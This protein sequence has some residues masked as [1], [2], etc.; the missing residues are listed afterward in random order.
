MNFGT[1]TVLSST[2]LGMR[3]TPIPTLIRAINLL[4]GKHGEHAASLIL[5]NI[6]TRW[7]P[8]DGT[9]SVRRRGLHW[10]L[11]LGD[12]LQRRLYFVG[13]YESITL[14]ALLARVRPHDTVLDVGAN[15]GAIALPI[16][17]RLRPPGQVIAVE[18]AKDTVERLRRHVFL[19]HLGDRIKVIN[20]GLSDRE[21]TAT[22]RSSAF[23]LGDVGTRTL[24]GNSAPVGDPVQLITG[25]ALRNQ[26]NISRFDIVK[27]DVEGHERFVLDGLTDAFQNCPPRVVVLELVANRQELSGGS[28]HSLVARMESMGYRG[29]AIRHR[30]L[31][32]ILP[33]FS[34]NT[35]FTRNE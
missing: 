16:A 12:N 19:N 24:E 2:L 35:I 13:T 9:Y 25:D 29:L 32:P 26:L 3:L 10:T 18:P 8:S 5:K 4:A 21:G 31:S 17:Q 11:D 14:N 1:S 33:S 7:V 34:G 15:I 30:G 6:P 28:S 22:L 23:G 27:I 20:A